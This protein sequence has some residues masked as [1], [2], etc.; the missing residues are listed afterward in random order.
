MV[1]RQ[2]MSQ[3][4][5]ASGLHFILI[6]PA[7]DQTLPAGQATAQAQSLHPFPTGMPEGKVLP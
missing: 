5:L 6:Y 7:G 4:P 3:Y 1:L 2:N